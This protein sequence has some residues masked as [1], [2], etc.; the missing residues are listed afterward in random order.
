MLSNLSPHIY[1]VCTARSGFAE[2]INLS[3]ARG[4]ACSA[5]SV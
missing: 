4:Q 5:N 1:Y 2:G 3:M